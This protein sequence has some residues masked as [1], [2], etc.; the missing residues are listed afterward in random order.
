MTNSPDNVAITTVGRV[1]AVLFFPCDPFVN[2]EGALCARD[3]GMRIL[4][5]STFRYAQSHLYANSPTTRREFSGDSSGWTCGRDK[6]IH[7][8]E[9]EKVLFREAKQCFAAP[10]YQHVTLDDDLYGTR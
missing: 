6:I 8:Q 3:I 5:Y 9:V 2:E 1:L 4:S 7:L 10:L